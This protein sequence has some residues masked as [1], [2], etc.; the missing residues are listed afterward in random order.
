MLPTPLAQLAREQ[1]RRLNEGRGPTTTSPGSPGDGESGQPLTFSPSVLPTPQPV[2]GVGNQTN[3]PGA[4]GPASALGR[5]GKYVRSKSK[6][7]R[8]K[9]KQWGMQHCEA[10]GKL[11]TGNHCVADCPGC[12]VGSFATKRVAELLAIETFGEAAVLHGEWDSVVANHTATARAFDNARAFVVKGKDGGVEQV[13]YKVEGH[14]VCRGTWGAF[15]GL[16]SWTTE[17]IHRRLMQ[18]ETMWSDAVRKTAAKA[19]RQLGATLEHAA[20]VWWKTRLTYYEMVVE[21]RVIQY[22]RSLNFGLMYADE[23]VLE[24]QLLGYNWKSVTKG[25]REKED[26]EGGGG[27]KKKRGDEAVRVAGDKNNED[28]A[29]YFWLLHYYT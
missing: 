19:S 4:E 29:R 7:K 8:M 22:P 27:S 9:W 24:M 28:S 15:R 11:I 12:D 26:G 13:A 21:S 2:R 17:T 3:E 5:R 25:E 1:R 20:M 23:F 10:F 18:G 14:Y 16:T 6:G